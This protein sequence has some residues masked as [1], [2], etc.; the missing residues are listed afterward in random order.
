MANI[1]QVMYI[2]QEIVKDQG[3]KTANITDIYYNC[4]RLV[5]IVLLIHNLD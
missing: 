4:G 5:N 3:K 2:Y 1:V